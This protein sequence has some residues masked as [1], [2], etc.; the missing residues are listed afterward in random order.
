M[1]NIYGITHMVRIITVICQI[2]IWQQYLYFCLFEFPNMFSEC[3]R[4]RKPVVIQFTK[5]P[6][7]TKS[8]VYTIVTNKFHHDY[9]KW[10]VVFQ[11]LILSFLFQITLQQTEYFQIFYFGAEIAA[12]TSCYLILLIIDTTCLT[13]QVHCIRSLKY[14]C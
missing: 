1:Q 13:I 4:V 6:H 12:N 9:V 11:V 8:I 3:Y 7:S 2:E 5:Y 10:D 14:V